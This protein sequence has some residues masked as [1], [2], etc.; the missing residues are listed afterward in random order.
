MANIL[1]RR[2][3][4]GFVR[5]PKQ[6]PLRMGGEGSTFRTHCDM[7]VGPC[8]CG[9]THEEHDGW[10]RSLLGQFNLKIETLFLT[11]RKGVVRIP[12]YWK[13]CGGC[14]TLVGPCA[15]GRTH[16]ADEE[17]VRD[18]LNLHFAKIVLGRK[19]KLR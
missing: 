9:E 14:D 7:L 19:C 5:Y 17:W 8:A 10:V 16:K 4:S 6:C 12:K 15:C 11:P 3:G 13:N 2:P 18:L 1:V